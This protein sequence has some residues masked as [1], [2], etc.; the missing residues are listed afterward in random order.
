MDHLPPDI[1][2]D[3]LEGTVSHEIAL[4]LHK[5]ISQGHFTLEKLNK[6]ITT[7]PYGPLDKQ[8]KPVPLSESFGD[9]IKQNAGRTWCLLRLLPLMVG[10]FVPAD[11][12]YW[13][14]LLE[15]KDIVE[16]AFA[17]KIS[18]CHVMSLCTKVQDHL[19]SFLE[20]FQRRLLPKHHFLLHYPRLIFFARTSSFML[21]Y[22]IRE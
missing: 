11:N 18:T 7:W 2:H 10:S 19:Q 8:N 17:P 3:L 15:L 9:K 21:V 6:I 4:V 5:L 16:L 22:E 12:E 13:N 20:L 1:L 14:F